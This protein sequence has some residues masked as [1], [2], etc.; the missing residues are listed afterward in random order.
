MSFLKKYLKFKNKKNALNKILN[1]KNKI[2]IL[3]L[4]NKKIF[5]I[6]KSKNI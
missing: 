3:V 4:S 2:Q 6:L 1:K 5:E